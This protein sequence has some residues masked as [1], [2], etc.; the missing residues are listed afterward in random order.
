MGLSCA[1]QSVMCRNDTLPNFGTSYSALA[2][3]AASAEAAR[4]RPMP[5][6]EAAPITWRNSRLLSCKAGPALLVDGGF[7]MQQQRHEVLDLLFAQVA[8]VAR[9]R[10]VGAGVVGLG[11]PDLAP[12][13]FHDGLGR[14]ALGIRHTAQLAV[15]IQARADG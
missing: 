1:W 15:V 13:V 12:R 7:G 11:V 5:A 14:S 8:H 2:A 4:P 9:A 6:T 3:V 10:H